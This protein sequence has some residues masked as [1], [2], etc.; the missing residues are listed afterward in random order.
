MIFIKQLAPYKGYDNY[1]AEHEGVTAAFHLDSEKDEW[2]Y[3]YYTSEDE[4]PFPKGVPLDKSMFD[5]ALDSFHTEFPDVKHVNP[6]GGIQTKLPVR[7]DLL[8]ADVLLEVSKV[9]AHGADSYGENNWKLIDV[10]DHINHALTHIYRFQIEDNSEDHLSH[11]ICRLMF[12][13]HLS[14]MEPQK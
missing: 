6:S 11:A 13:A 2:L 14:I 7:C 3:T 9:L 1:I 8:P 12:A 4:L 10:N 5:N